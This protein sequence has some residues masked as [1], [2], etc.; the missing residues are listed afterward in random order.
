M[1]PVRPSL[2]RIFGKGALGYREPVMFP[3]RPSLAEISGK[4]ARGCLFF[5]NFSFSIKAKFRFHTL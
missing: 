1:P 4:G 5:E 3:V 2:A